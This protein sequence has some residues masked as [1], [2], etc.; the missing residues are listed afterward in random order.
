MPAQ[1][2]PPQGIRMENI[3]FVLVSPKNSGNIG[4][5]A[6]AIKNM[7]FKDLRLVNPR[8][9]TWMEAIHMA[10]GA[11]DLLEQARIETS[12]E[13]ALADIQWV[14]G[15]TARS[16]RY[17]KSVSLPREIARLTVSMS[18]KNK[19]AF[20]FGSEKHGLTTDEISFCHQ[21]VTIPTRK[22]FWSL[23]LSQAVMVM[24]W[25]LSQAGGDNLL[26]E[27]PPQPN[28]APQ[29]ELQGL[30]VH[31]EQVLREI[32]FI[33]PV[34]SRH[35]MLSMK[36]IIYQKTLTSKEVRVFRGFLRRLHYSKHFSAVNDV[37]NSE[38]SRNL[39]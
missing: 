36:E 13:E 10:C 6:R 25:E 19:T 17:N 31:L 15:A 27:L 22:N 18:Q 9:Q 4:A 2:S 39:G 16:R 30:F 14:I 32:D 38:S 37:E 26:S 28:M 8:P 29:R 35:V 21:V 12:L 20:I 24:A 5:V 3:A 33:T 1:N 34:T 23:N 7:G 11:E